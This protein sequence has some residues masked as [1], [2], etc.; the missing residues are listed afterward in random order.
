MS[1][2]RA[3]DLARDVLIWIAGEPEHTSRFL[4]ATGAD[5]QDLRRGAD[6]PEFLGF[7]LDFLLAGDDVLLAFCEA[8]E[9]RPEDAVAARAALPGGDLP[10]WT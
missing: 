9:W 6:N 2:E 8:H 3:V 4:A 5:T 1:R 10:N 7:L